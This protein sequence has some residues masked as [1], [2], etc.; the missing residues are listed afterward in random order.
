MFPPQQSCEL[1]AQQAVPQ[2]LVLQFDA[3]VPPQPSE[4]APTRQA[5]HDGVQQ[6]WL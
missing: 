3:Q 2:H 5:A 1:L 6:A 4:A